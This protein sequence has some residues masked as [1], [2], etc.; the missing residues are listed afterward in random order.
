LTTVEKAKENNKKSQPREYKKR[1][2]SWDQFFI[3]YSPCEKE[4]EMAT[5]SI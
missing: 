4:K 1:R 3:F 2:K 5:Q